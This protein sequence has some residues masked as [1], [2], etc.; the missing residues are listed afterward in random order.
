MMIVASRNERR[1]R[2]EALHQLEAQ[3]TAIEFQRAFGKGERGQKGAIPD[4]SR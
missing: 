2:T 4:C 3:H 1:L